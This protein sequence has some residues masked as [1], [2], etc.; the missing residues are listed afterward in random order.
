[1]LGAELFEESKEALLSGGVCY[2]FSPLLTFVL[3]KRDKS[4]IP[5][6]RPLAF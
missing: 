5:L 1:M 6:S 3:Y 4:E 2:V